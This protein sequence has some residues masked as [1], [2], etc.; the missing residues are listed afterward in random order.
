M[1]SRGIIVYLRGN[2]SLEFDI[3][4]GCGTSVEEKNGQGGFDSI[5]LAVLQA[6][7]LNV[8][9][10]GSA[11][12]NLSAHLGIGNKVHFQVVDR[13]GRTTSRPSILEQGGVLLWQ[14]RSLTRYFCLRV[15]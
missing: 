15:K 5:F 6:P 7:S 11:P 4:L 3:V 13:S 12:E 9:Y 8:T 1:A 14:S 2:M 10:D